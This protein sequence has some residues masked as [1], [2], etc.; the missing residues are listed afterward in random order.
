M[1]PGSRADSCASCTSLPVM[2]SAG[3]TTEREWPRSPDRPQLAP[4]AQ[5]GPQAAVEAEAVDRCRRRDGAEA[6]QLH[7][8]PLEAALLEHAPRR[9]VADPRARLQRLEAERGERMVDHG[10]RRL[11]GV[12]LAPIRHAKPVADLLGAPD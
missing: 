2:R 9:R 3:T 7:A 6:L 12:A 10:A 11:G 4:A 1:G 5:R 8:G